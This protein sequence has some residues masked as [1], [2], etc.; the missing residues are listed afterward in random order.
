MMWS[1]WLTGGV[2]DVAFAYVGSKYFMNKWNYQFDRI[3]KHER[4]LIHLVAIHQYT[5]Q[6]MAKM[7]Y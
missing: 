1:G 5:W 4:K 7:Y 6:Y 2:L 3:I